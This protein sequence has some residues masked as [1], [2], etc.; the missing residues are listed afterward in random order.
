MSDKVVL[1]DI[2]Y[3]IKRNL[4]LMN[5]LK[6]AGQMGY[7]LARE[8]MGG[9]A[10]YMPDGRPC[11]AANFYFNQ[12]TGE[13]EY[14]GNFQE[15]PR[16]IRLRRASGV[17]RIAIDLENYSKEIVEIYY[18]EYYAP[19]EFRIIKISDATE[20]SDSAKFVLQKSAELYN[21]NSR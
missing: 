6:H 1:N 2:E 3:I 17:F 14:F 15:V 18:R 21:K 9:N 8:T 5:G 10:G 19:L 4:D 7:L 12:K 16:E 11:A 20:V 13:I